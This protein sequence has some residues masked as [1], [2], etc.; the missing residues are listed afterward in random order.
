M[1]T[2]PASVLSEDDLNGTDARLLDL[3]H[4]GRI[5]PPYAAEQLEK[6]RE[7]VSER[8]IRLKEH[9]HVRRIHRGLY[10]L[11]DDPREE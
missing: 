9:D 2:T 1:G 4:D 5:T 7:Y 10:E 11:V 3:L 6:S 8:L